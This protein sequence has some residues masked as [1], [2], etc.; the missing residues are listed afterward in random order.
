MFKICVVAPNY[1]QRLKKKII[2]KNRQKMGALI[3]SVLRK[4]PIFAA[5]EKMVSLP[6]FPWLSFRNE[7]QKLNV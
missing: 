1:Y 6:F 4:I 7:Y 3:F 5:Y 2:V